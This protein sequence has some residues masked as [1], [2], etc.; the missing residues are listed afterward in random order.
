MST[1]KTRGTCSLMIH[2][3]I[4]S[5]TVKNVKFDGGCPGNALG[6]SKMVEG[7]DVDE[8]IEKLKDIKCGRKDTS[9][10]DQLALALTAWKE[11]K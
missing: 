1:W 2:F 9:C 11:Q 8:V 6:L 3:D 4:E 5:N 7:M 10:P